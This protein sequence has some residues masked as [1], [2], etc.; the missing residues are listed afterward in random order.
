[1]GTL[2]LVSTPIGNLEDISL[3]ALR[4]L[5]TATLIAAEDTRVTGRLLERYHIKTPMVSYHEHNKLSRIDK[6][7]DHLAVGDVALVSDAGTPG[8]NDPG[9]ELVKS[10]LAAGCEVSP[11]PGPASP[12]ASLVGSGLPTDSFTF[13]GFVPRKSSERQKRLREV[14]ALPYTLIFL[15]TPHRLLSS[16]EDMLTELG[17]RDAVV[18]RELT[19]IHEEY[20]RGT[21]SSLIEHFSATEPKGEICLVV[22]GNTE[23]MERWDQNRIQDAAHAGLKEAA[24]ANVLA[25]ELARESGW[26]KNDV[27]KIIVQIKQGKI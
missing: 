23:G 2:Y 18:A 22:A 4:I 9:Y 3:R 24:S 26:R 1:M 27:Y 10:A 12:I 13:L 21:L 17:D 7:L 20:K 14:R 15:E 19:K 11:I 6:I 16:L 5:Q 25:A 8:L